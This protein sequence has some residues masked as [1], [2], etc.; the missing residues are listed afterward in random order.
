M[1]GPSE[2]HTCEECGTE[3]TRVIGRR[4][5]SHSHRWW[6]WRCEAYRRVSLAAERARAA[7]LRAQ[8]SEGD[9]G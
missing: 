8:P 3:L 2:P 5:G 6:C 7:F 4:R 1:S 9:D